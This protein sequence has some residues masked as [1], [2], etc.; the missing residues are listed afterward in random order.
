M[1]LSRRL[2]AGSANR[3]IS[4]YD[5]NSTN[6]SVPTSRIEDLVAIPTCLEYF[7]WPAKTE[8]KLE[9]ILVGDSLGNIHKYDFKSL[10]WHTCTYNPGKFLQ[11][12]QCHKNEIE[13]SYKE[14]FSKQWEEMK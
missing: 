5:L 2:V 9:T 11:K 8:G 13:A 12:N 7:R 14:S 1:T 4:F 3:Q 6:Y 10:D